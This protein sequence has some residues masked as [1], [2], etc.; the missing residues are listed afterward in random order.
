MSGARV[1]QNQKLKSFIVLLL[2]FYFFCLTSFSQNKQ[3]F[4]T[5]V[6][7]NISIEDGL[8][9]NSVTCILQ[10][11]LG[12]M[13]FGTQN[14]L[15]KYDGYSMKVYKPDTA[16]NKS[17]SGR[18]IVTL[19]E[20][21]NKTLWI[22]TL[23]GL[24]K[25]NREDESF[26]SYLF[27]SND[28]N[29][30]S[31]DLV[32]T[33]YED[34]FGRFWIGTLCGL[35][36]FNR[37][38]E[39]FTRF[40]FI[41]SNSKAVNHIQA[42]QYSLGIIAIT[43]D[44]LSNDL[45]LG[46]ALEGLWIFNI[47]ENKISRYEFND[48]TDI[49][50]KIGWIQNFYKARDGRIWT[51]SL[52]SLS[53]FDPVS[54]EIKC[55]LD[56]PIKE[57]EKYSE[58]SFISA[59]V[60]ED[61]YGKI[62]AGF[63][64]GDKGLFCLDPNTGEINNFELFPNKP[65]NTMLNKIFSVYED[66][67]GIIWIGTWS[68][69]V[70]KWN[71]IE[72][73][74][75]VL[76]SNTL[77]PNN[78]SS[79][80]VYSLICDP[81][82][83]TWYCTPGGLDRYDQR[84][85]R[86]THYL[87]DEKC[88]TDFMVYAAMIDHSGDLW[89]GTSNCGLV[90]FNSKI[91]SYRF[92]LNN[93]D[94]INLIDKTVLCLF[95]DHL[96][97]I[98]IGT[99]GFGL[100]KYDHRNSSLEQYKNDPDDSLSLSGNQ[101]LSI[102]EDH[103]GNLWVGTNLNGLNKY[104]RETGTFS[105]VGFQ[106]C[107][108][109][110]E[111]SQNRFWVTEYNSGLNLF[112]TEK[113]KVITNYS[114]QN[115]LASNTIVGVLEDDRKNL[116][117]ATDVG[118]SRVN[119]QNKT[120]KNFAVENKFSDVFNFYIP[121]CT[122]KGIDGTLYINTRKGVVIFNPVNVK[123]DPTPPQV[124]ISNLSLFNKPKEKL[125]Y[126]G[127]IPEAKG[128]TLPYNQN[129]LRF[130]YVALQYNEPLKNTY[131]YILENFD[132]EWIDAGN[133]RNATYTNLEPGEYIFRV[134][135]ANRDGVWNKKG[136]SLKIIITPPWWRTNLAYFFFALILFGMLYFIW[137][138]QLKRI[139]IKH[140]YEMSKFEAEKLHEVDEIKS[141]F[142]TNISHEF[143]TPLTLLLGPVRQM[144]EKVNDS[145]MK[146]DLRIVH[147]N[148]NKLLEL[149][150]QLLDISKIESGHMKLQTSAQNVI[151]LLKALVLSFA[152]Y[153]ERKNITLKFSSPEDEIIAYIDNEKIEKII[154][155]IISNA[156]KFTP[157]G[158]LIEVKVV[159]NDKYINVNVRDTGIG[160]PKEKISKIFNRF[161]QVNGSR[162]RMQEGTG[163]GLSITKELIELH[164]GKIS[165]ESEE[166]KG[167]IIT[168]SIPLGK[169]HLKHDEI[170]EV[171][172]EK[173]KEILKNKILLAPEEYVTKINDYK[174][175][176]ELY[177]NESLPLLLIVEDNTDVRNYIINNLKDN[178]KILEAVNGEEGWNK[179]MEHIPDLIISDVMMPIMDGFELC[180]K[181]KTDE[182]TSH[183]PVILLTAKAANQDKIEG[184]ET[185]ADEY[186][187]KPFMP[188]ILK[189]RIKN[190]IEQR[191]RIHE[192]FRNQDIIDLEKIKIAS[193]DKK[194]LQKVFNI[195][196]EN[197]SDSSFNVQLLAEKSIVSYQ[198]LHKKIV[199]LTGEPPVELIRRIRLKRASELIKSK[200]GNI[201]EI[202]LEVGFNNPAYFSECFKKQFG[203]SPSQY[204]R[205]L[206]DN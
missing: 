71:K 31:S 56:F 93:P 63:Y 100:Y 171:A 28:S 135:S 42:N 41:D 84:I 3:N 121:S 111:D 8:P 194:F 183:I 114:Q 102:L 57:E 192:H 66:R 151:V 53:S 131:K 49:N 205:K 33:I 43:D 92:Y 86:Y 101:V 199:S 73:K 115:G 173:D 136:A 47:N 130:D 160:I 153:A 32:H 145:K 6:F 118:I 133:Q 5:P 105:Y 30:I 97:Y 117:F 137:K 87:E 20:D 65:Q 166:G 181:I 26:K 176:N 112:D 143:R 172:E 134:S 169:G 9:E 146:D 202:A 180:K 89:L 125:N 138:M 107:V 85:H 196:T 152:S 79:P 96:G 155:N 140:E 175:E 129:D 98:W 109:L 163:I 11:Y 1:I 15:V 61:R 25:F 75:T 90:K 156:F 55:Y 16:D 149:V 83:Y 80:T 184:F 132:N 177:E 186:I 141:R 148:A 23:Y 51:A 120:T 116:W 95:Q 2:S 201:S 36:L 162:T 59:S 147:K 76:Q 150:N 159:K 69:G 13:W 24:N 113:L 72:N 200:F 18:E 206:I 74:F 108:S 174:I 142:F 185:G 195:I 27:N 46:T 158:G 50:K 182:R 82:G 204:T 39:R 94:E 144:I 38:S 78:L 88:V 52:N 190:L 99:A 103:S 123:D 44:P 91:S 168:I 122:G 40:Y 187:M 68:T 34:R 29:S 77:D 198:V 60:I 119:P 193:F 21:S 70:K 67:S 197:I 154:N 157:D 165:I 37:D 19:F 139:R 127:F 170:I 106:N 161:Y 45:L 54:R 48:S 7:E 22:G 4:I 12:Y 128:I 188:E 164:K 104:N 14:G 58:R 124:V 179:S 35:N 126:N 81:K 10:D 110:F 191:S 64:A 189:A 178:Y 17:I 203:L 62:I 167:T